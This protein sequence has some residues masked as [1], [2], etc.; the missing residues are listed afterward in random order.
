MGHLVP[1][2]ASRL[3]EVAQNRLVSLVRRW[4]CLHRYNTLW[5]L[6]PQSQRDTPLQRRALAERDRE[7]LEQ[8]PSPH[9]V[10]KPYD[11]LLRRPNEARGHFR[12]DPSPQSLELFLVSRVDAVAPQELQPPRLRVIAFLRRSLSPANRLRLFIGEPPSDDT[13]VRPWPYPCRRRP[14]GP[15]PMNMPGLYAKGLPGQKE[16]YDSHVNGHATGDSRRGRPWIPWGPSV[17]GF[18]LRHQLP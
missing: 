15:F 17:A 12:G 5:S 3:K 6:S 2:K 16:E 10:T 8:S 18:A 11:H 1:E 9:L 14:V 13:R 7:N 4:Q